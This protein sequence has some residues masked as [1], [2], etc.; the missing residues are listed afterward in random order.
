MFEVPLNTLRRDFSFIKLYFSDELLKYIQE[1]SF[2]FALSFSET[3]C[4]IM[5]HQSLNVIFGER[6][7]GGGFALI[8]KGKKREKV[9]ILFRET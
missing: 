7:G 1:L 4:K 9:N 2:K 8:R 6:I 5:K 3:T